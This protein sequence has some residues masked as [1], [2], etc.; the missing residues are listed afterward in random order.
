MCTT[1]CPYYQTPSYRDVLKKNIR[2]SVLALLFVKTQLKR[3][4]VTAV[5]LQVLMHQKDFMYLCKSDNMHDLF[6]C[7]ENDMTC[8]FVYIHMHSKL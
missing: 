2:C 8:T 6:C 5:I 3:N 4:Y 1:Q 7:R